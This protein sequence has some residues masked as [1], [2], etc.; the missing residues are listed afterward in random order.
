MQALLKY[1]NTL[2]MVTGN[3]YRY[4]WMQMG[5]LGYR[6]SEP[7]AVPKESPGIL[8]EMFHAYLFDLEYTKEE[9]AKV[10]FLT[11]SDLETTY[12]NAQGKLK[13]I[14]KA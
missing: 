5:S 2:S 14:R 13:I 1:S 6:R 11:V 10:L 12:F 3:Q 4:L 8:Q 9:L 7:V